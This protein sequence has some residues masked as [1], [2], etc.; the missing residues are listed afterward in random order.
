M[1]FIYF[2]NGSILLGFYNDLSQVEV[3]KTGFLM[4]SLMIS[5]ALIVWTFWLP[6]SRCLS[7]VHRLWTVPGRK[8][9]IVLFPMRTLIGLSSGGC[10][11]QRAQGPL[12]LT[13]PFS[14][15]VCS[16]R[17]IMYQFTQYIP[18]QDVFLSDVGRWITSDAVFPLW[19]IFL[20]QGITSYSIKSQ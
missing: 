12:S 15:T 20:L 9:K 17:I 6:S 13:L 11:H 14:S 5:D 7:Q 4:A 3:V 18:D 19:Y 10:E 2:K 8:T 1:G 16:L